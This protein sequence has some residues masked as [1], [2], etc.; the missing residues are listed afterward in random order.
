MNHAGRFARSGP[1]L[2]RGADFQVCRIAGCQTRGPPACVRNADLE[3]SDTAGLETCATLGTPRMPTGERGVALRLPP[4]PKSLIVFPHGHA[5][6][7]RQ[8]DILR[9]YLKDESVNL[10]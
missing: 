3:I 4:Q 2:L 10:V 1:L 5:L 6:L 7:R 9:R 8:L